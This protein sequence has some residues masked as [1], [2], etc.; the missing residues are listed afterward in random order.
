MVDL[1]ARVPRLP[2][3]GET[4]IGTSFAIGFGGKGSNQ[5]VMAARLGAQVTVVVKLGNDVFAEQTRSN[6][7]T[8]GIWTDYVTF[9]QERASGVAPIAV[10]QASG[11]NSII[12]VPGANES[13]TVNDVRAAGDEI[14]RADVVLC[15]LESPIAATIEAFKLARA[16]D[17]TTVLNPAPALPLGDD[18]LALTDVL[19]PNETEAAS[20]L[21][22]SIATDDESELAVRRLIELGP[23]TVVVTLG[24]RGAIYGIRD[25]EIERVR[26]DSVDAVDSAG[27]GDAFVGSLAYFHAVGFPLELAVR[28]ACHIATLSVLKPGTQ[29]SFPNRSDIRAL[30]AAWAP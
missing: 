7:E 25:G 29:A 10:D 2:V 22:T 18:L 4:I 26:A 21:G 17:T 13:L 16:G 24:E 15:Q 28:R 23:R 19:V 5:A 27:A 8:E 14:Q 11:Q 30:F 3:P 9:D 1:I 20:L 12:V 6:Y